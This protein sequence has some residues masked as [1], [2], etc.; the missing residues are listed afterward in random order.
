MTL[1]MVSTFAGVGGFDLAFE[2]AG[3]RT[4]ATVEIDRNC[5]GVL[6]EHWPSTT[7]LTD[8]LEVSGD[9]LRSTGFVPGTGILTGGFPCQDLSVAGRRAGMDRGTRSGLFWELDRIMAEISP[10]WVVFENVPGLL[11]SNGGRDLGT[12]VGTLADRGYGFAYRV[13][14]AQHFGVPQRRRRIFIVGRLADDGRGPAAVLFDGAGGVGDSAPRP[15]AWTALA[16]R[17]RG[18]PTGS[19]RLLAET[20]IVRSLTTRQGTSGVDLTD[21]EAGH[22]V[23]Y[24]KSRRA[25]S[26]DDHETW[27]P[28][29]QTNTL[30]T[31]DN[32]GD[33]RATE[34]VVEHDAST[35]V[36][37]LTPV[38]C[39]RLQGFPD[40]WTRVVGRK[41]QSDSARYKQ[42]GNSLAVP[43]VEWIAR[44]LVQVDASLEGELVCV[45][46]GDDLAA[47]GFA[48]CLD[49]LEAGAGG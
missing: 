27:V 41:V 14:D 42:M 17:T 49:C 45:E 31:F 15:Q 12:V 4:V 10:R 26:A 34:L 47:E 5:R 18:R 39:E 28:S 2:R 36:R 23:T 24:R 44:R 3:V 16:G 32:T 21:A 22:V 11:S 48:Y 13:L 7:H 19:G 38:E 30:N 43:V 37:R 20:G 8:I 29:D 35:V 46:C 9:D 33:I 6:A 40:D 1:N 25:M